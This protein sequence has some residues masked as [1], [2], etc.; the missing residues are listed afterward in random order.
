MGI[1]D[2]VFKS[3]PIHVFSGAGQMTDAAK[4]FLEA[5]PDTATI[6]DTV[7]KACEEYIR[8]T[9]QLKSFDIGCDEKYQER[10]IRDHNLAIYTQAP[11]TMCKRIIAAGAKMVVTDLAADRNLLVFTNE[12]VLFW[13]TTLFKESVLFIPL[14]IRR[15][16]CPLFIPEV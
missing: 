2:S 9:M 16:S 1:F 15:S 5:H 6:L 14:P 11:E 10:K 8:E 7:E 13:T 12:M 4:R 3:K